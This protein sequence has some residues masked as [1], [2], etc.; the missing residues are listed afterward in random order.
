MG[1]D[2]QTSAIEN[3]G[4][5]SHLSQSLGLFSATTIVAGSMIG[6]G[7]FIVSADISR[8]VGSPGMLLA[9]WLFTALLTVFAAFSYG[10]LAAHL[11]KAGGQ[12]VF[13]KE[14]WGELPAFLYGWA[15][16]SVIQT[17]T[18]AAVAVAFGKFL[19]IL[20]PEISSAVLI[21][22]T[23]QF[24]ISSQ[25]ILAVVL[26]LGLTA[27]NCTGVKNGAAL[28]NLFTSLKVLALFS[29][30][31]VGGIA[32]SHLWSSSSSIGNLVPFE[33][34]FSLPTPLDTSGALGLFA[35]ATVGALFSS[36]AWNNVTFI[37]GEIKDPRRNLPKALLIG[38]LLVVSLYFLV[39]VSYL[40][41]LSLDQIKN[42]PEDR[43]ATAV[44][45]Q[46]LGSQGAVVMALVIMVS[47]FGCLN[48]ML[49]SGAR[50]LYAMA[51][52]RLLFPQFSQIHPT[53]HT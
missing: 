52:D 51:Q 47:T 23:P 48:G 5:S 33:W 3:E 28:Q 18:V 32:G 26:L 41:V 16:F 1:E 19:G 44:M 8:Q 27:F 11:P 29:L 36:D 37:G 49:L 43:V 13:L 31:I 46:L 34:S 4:A 15:L 20:I 38:T 25:Q 50:V 12:Y 35:A 7:I 22:I 40:N 21:P 42:A 45:S 2:L 53:T 39:N 24:G 30:I 10:K 9:I 6:S 14:A 17:G